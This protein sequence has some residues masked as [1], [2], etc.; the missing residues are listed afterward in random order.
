MKLKKKIDVKEEEEE[1]KK[2]YQFELTFYTCDLRYE[3]MITILKNITKFNFQ[4][5]Q[6]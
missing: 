1:E 4:S 3:N 5:I 2:Q 6:Y